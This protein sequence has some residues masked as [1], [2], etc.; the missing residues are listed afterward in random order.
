MAMKPKFAAFAL[1]KY[2]ANK[3]HFY[4]KNTIFCHM[5]ILSPYLYLQSWRKQAWKCTHYM[6]TG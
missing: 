5:L 3:L 1:S 6:K 4:R 2:V